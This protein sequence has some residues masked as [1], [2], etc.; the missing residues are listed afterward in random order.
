M[1]R[2][3]LA[4]AV[5]AVLVADSSTLQMPARVR[6][7]LHVTADVVCRGGCGRAVVSSRW[8]LLYH[9]SLYLPNNWKVKHV[10]SQFISFLKIPH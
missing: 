8:Q 5:D 3:D 9:L 6:D 2:R 1:I 7:Q 4:D 10:P